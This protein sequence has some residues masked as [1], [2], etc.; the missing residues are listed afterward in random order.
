MRGEIGVSNG[1]YHPVRLIPIKI[2]VVVEGLLDVLDARLR[3]LCQ[4]F[5]Q[6]RIVVLVEVDIEAKLRPGVGDGAG[7]RRWNAA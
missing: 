2:L 1:R 3:N 6:F 5:G 4:V 7:K